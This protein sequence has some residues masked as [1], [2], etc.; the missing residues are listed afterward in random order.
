M[1]LVNRWKLRTELVK[2]AHKKVQKCA[3]LHILIF[4]DITHVDTMKKKRLPL[5]LYDSVRLTYVK[6]IYLVFIIH[7]S[8]QH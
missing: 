7:S 8:A 5:G 1:Y 6:D 2:I 4:S 3:V